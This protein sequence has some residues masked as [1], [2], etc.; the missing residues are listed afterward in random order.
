MHLLV[1]SLF[2]ERTHQTCSRPGLAGIPVA[3]CC[4][5]CTTWRERS[6]R[7]LRATARAPRTSSTGALYMWQSGK[8]NATTCSLAFACCR[9]MQ[10]SSCRDA[11]A[12]QRAR[13]AFLSQTSQQQDPL[14]A[15]SA[16]R[17]VDRLRD[18]VKKF[19]RCLVLGG[20]GA[21]SARPH[22]MLECLPN[23]MRLKQASARSGA[24]CWQ[25]IVNL[26]CTAAFQGFSAHLACRT[27][28]PASV[29][30]GRGLQQGRAAHCVRRPSAGDG[31]TG[32]RAHH[33]TMPGQLS[34][35]ARVHKFTEAAA[36]RLHA[37]CVGASDLFQLCDTA[38]HSASVALLAHMHG[39]LAS[40]PG[41][42]RCSVV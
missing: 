41:P 16:E 2:L 22:Y 36:W 31:R 32:S 10:A 11:K 20:A 7:L 1:L 24:S 37:L 28:F 4:S 33:K 8:A 25:G 39:L 15:E 14:H 40:R 12:A 21:W 34:P 29:P 38:V 5:A 42:R 30:G 13:M 18:V 26:K 27:L 6:A 23:V 35:G 9:H 3:V 17:L 19:R